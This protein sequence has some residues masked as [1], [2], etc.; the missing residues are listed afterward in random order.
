LEVQSDQGEPG[1]EPKPC[2]ILSDVI[3]IRATKL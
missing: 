2:S 3:C 1:K